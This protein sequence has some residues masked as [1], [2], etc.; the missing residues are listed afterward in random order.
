MIRRFDNHNCSTI[1]SD[2]PLR[3]RQYRHKR[4]ILDRSSHYR[5]CSQPRLIKRMTSNFKTCAPLAQFCSCRIVKRT[6]SFDLWCKSLT[7][8]WGSA[9]SCAPEHPGVCQHYFL[10]A[11][12]GCVSTSMFD[13]GHVLACH[14]N[15]LTVQWH[16]RAFVDEF[17]TPDAQS[18]PCTWILLVKYA[19]IFCKWMIVSLDFN[20]QYGVQQNCD[21][22]GSFDFIL[23]YYI[24]VTL[25]LGYSNG[26]HSGQ[27]Y[28]GMVIY[29]TASSCS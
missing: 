19:H 29:S 23:W 9:Q 17:T 27:W 21:D 2:I 7:D 15:S 13:S 4:T 20:W 24:H 8:L 18:K 6:T 28:H 25:R 14:G 22:S 1:Y 3:Q 26:I 10:K 5:W 16:N 12:S 11:V